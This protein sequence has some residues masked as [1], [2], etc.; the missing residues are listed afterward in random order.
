MV[1]LQQHK[2]KLGEFFLVVEVANGS[3]FDI[4]VY[5]K[6]FHMCRGVQ[7]LDF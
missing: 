3:Y 2:C 4:Y 7:F 5:Y 1:I 6:T